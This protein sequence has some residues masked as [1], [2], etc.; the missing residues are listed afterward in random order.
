[1]GDPSRKMTGLLEKYSCFIPQVFFELLLRF[2]LTLSELNLSLFIELSK[3]SQETFYFSFIHPMLPWFLFKSWTCLS[4]LCVFPTLP[5]G[6]FLSYT[7]T[8]LTDELQYSW[9]L[10]VCVKSDGHVIKNDL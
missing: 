5:V 1:M 10:P 3:V 4:V 7:M 9:K 2:S 6:F 8:D